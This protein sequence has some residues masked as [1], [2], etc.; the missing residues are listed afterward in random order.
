VQEA[1]LPP[2]RY[3]CQPVYLCTDWLTER[4]D[5]TLCSLFTAV[6]GICAGNAPI[7]ETKEWLV[8]VEASKVMFGPEPSG[9]CR[10]GFGGTKGMTLRVYVS[11]VP[12]G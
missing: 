4:P 7:A 2:T 3:E 10:N 12:Q 9:R 6:G 1:R 5:A 8:H 11:C